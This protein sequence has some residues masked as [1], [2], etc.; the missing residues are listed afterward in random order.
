MCNSA[1]LKR[2]NL[3]H[4]NWKGKNK[5]SFTTDVIIHVS[6]NKLSM[7][8]LIA[9]LYTRNT[10]RKYTRKRNTTLSSNVTYLGVN[11]TKDTQRHDKHNYEILR[12]KR[13]I[14]GET[15]YV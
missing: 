15:Y 1:L 13:R 10:I 11:L 6:G 2:R 4:N 5:N 14:K 3:T 8:K 9:F 7:Q 12:D